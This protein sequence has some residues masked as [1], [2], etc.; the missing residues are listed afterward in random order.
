MRERVTTP[1]TVV[2]TSA[3]TSL[4]VEGGDGADGFEAHLPL[5]SGK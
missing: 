3:G 2:S 4:L 5:R 1:S